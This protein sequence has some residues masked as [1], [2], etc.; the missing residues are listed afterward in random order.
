MCFLQWVQLLLTIKYHDN[1]ISYTVY[2]VAL[3]QID[4]DT[5]FIDPAQVKYSYNL[6]LTWS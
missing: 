6:Y 4:V 3:N 5:R 2:P 1:N